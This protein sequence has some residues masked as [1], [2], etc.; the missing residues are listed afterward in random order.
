MV[1]HTENI[2]VCIYYYYIIIIIMYIY[3]YIYIMRVRIIWFVV[4]ANRLI[5]KKTWHSG[6]RPVEGPA[7]FKLLQRREAIEKNI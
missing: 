7:F 2:Y 3:I 6:G 1:H 4:L 5:E